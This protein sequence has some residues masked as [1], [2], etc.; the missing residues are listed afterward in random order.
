MRLTP[1]TKVIFGTEN[2]AHT[3]GTVLKVNRVMAKVRQDEARNSRPIGTMWN[4]PPRF[5]KTLDGKFVD[6][7]WNIVDQSPISNPIST[8]NGNPDEMPED[9][10]IHGH[11]HELHILNGI[12][13]N[14]SPE[15]LTCDGECSHTQVQ[16]RRAILMRKMAAVEILM[17]R[18]MSETVC[19]NAIQRLN[20]LKKARDDRLKTLGFTTH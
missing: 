17:G 15:N 1:G 3:Q 7:D 20:E 16:Q 14:L 12:Y 13:A 8:S 11:D 6:S 18:K 9:G 19:Y 2:G 10:W 5:M 4:V